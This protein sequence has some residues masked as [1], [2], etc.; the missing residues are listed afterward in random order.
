MPRTTND[1]ILREIRQ[2]KKMQTTQGKDIE[3][4]TAWQQAEDAYRKALGIVRQEQKDKL[5]EQAT[6][7][8]IKVLKEVYPII[9]ILG[10]IIYAY[11]NS[12]GIH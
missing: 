11:A 3:Q 2:V 9:G 5:N 4:L 8:W 12:K 6:K 7:M 1:D 10:A